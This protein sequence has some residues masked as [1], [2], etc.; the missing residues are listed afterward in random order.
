MHLYTYFHSS[1]AFRVRIALNLKGLT[2]S[3]V[4]VHLTRSGG[5]QFRPEFLELNP[6]GLVPVL[7]DGAH[8]LPQSLAIIEYL[9]EAYPQPPLF[10]YSI[11]ER[12]RV[13]ALA[14][15]I[16]CEIHPLNN[17]RVLNYLRHTLGVSDDAK[18]Q[19][20]AHWV[21]AGLATVEGMLADAAQPS[22]FCHGETPTLADC[23]LVPQ[24][25]NA[26]RFQCRLDAFPRCT[27]ITERC[28]AL[29]AFKQA[30]PS[31]QPDAVQ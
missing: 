2:Y 22:A 29:E 7:R 10:P 20:Y 19:W 6:A 21:E 11:V 8:L 23:L 14:L 27:E 18:Q 17:L 5:E 26:R 12:A 4:P 9:E 30:S 3:H 1:A 15:T 13:R 16:A 25:F 28:M 24:V 31:A